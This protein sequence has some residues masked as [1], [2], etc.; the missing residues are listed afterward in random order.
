MCIIQFLSMSYFPT[1]DE[2]V[3]AIRA[4]HQGKSFVDPAIADKVIKGFLETPGVNEDE[5]VYESLSDREKQAG[6]TRRIGAGG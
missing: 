1:G 2:L 4:V 5:V 6:L 3:A